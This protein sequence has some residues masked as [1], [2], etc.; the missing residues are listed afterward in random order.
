MQA[1]STNPMNLYLWPTTT[2]V[3][4][5]DQAGYFDADDV[6]IMTSNDDSNSLAVEKM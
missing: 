4:L 2:Q 6:Y 3:D 5:F 1:E